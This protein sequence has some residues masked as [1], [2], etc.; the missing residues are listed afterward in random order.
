MNKEISFQHEKDESSD[1]VGVFFVLFQRAVN[2]LDRFK[3]SKEM[4]R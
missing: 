3:V 4:R 1:K 2:T